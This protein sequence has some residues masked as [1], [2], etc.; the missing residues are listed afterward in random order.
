MSKSK[1]PA[2]IVS[3]VLD[4]SGSMMSVWEPTLSGINEYINQL[5]NDGN[6]YRLSLTVFDTEFEK[7]YVATPIADVKEITKEQYKPRGMTALYDA[8]CK[9]IADI[10]VE[11][12]DKTPV[13]FVIM[14]DG[15]ENSSK[16]YT[17]VQMK[18]VIERLE[19]QGNWTFVFM[20][21]N[22]DS[23]ATA[24]VYGVQN[25]ANVVNYHASAAGTKAAFSTL[26]RSTKNYAMNM[27]AS[28]ENA[29]AS[30]FSKADKEEIETKA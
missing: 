5:K 9:T 18:A 24:A 20:G 13:L 10:E 12:G 19:K 6:R 23:Y 26:T 7:L 2:T 8:V 25:A 4:M 27:S 11:A 29:T 21:A 14:T 22:Q 30:F 17:Q 3:V 28:A 16:E 1:K 15:Q